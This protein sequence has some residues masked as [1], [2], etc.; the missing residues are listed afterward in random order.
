MYKTPTCFGHF[1]RTFSGGSPL[2]FVPLFSSR[3]L[4]SQISGMNSNGTKH[5]GETPE[6]GRKK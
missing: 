4:R 6:D 2:C 3:D 1:S 5:S